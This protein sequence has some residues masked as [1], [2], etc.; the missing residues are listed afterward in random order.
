MADPQLAARGF[1]HALEHPR[2]DAIA[3]PGAPAQLSA[4][5]AGGFAPAPETPE[6]IGLAEL[7]WAPRDA[8]LS[9]AAD[10]LPPLAGVKLLDL[11]QAWIG[12]YAAMLI[13][14]L[15]AEAIK[16]ES[17]RRPDVWRQWGWAPVPL[18]SVD[19]DVVNASPNYNSV[20][21]Q[22]RSL[23]LDLKS[24]AGRG[25]F[26]R[27]AAKADLVME[28]YTPHVLEGF[29]LTWAALAE[30][31]PQ[32]VAASFCGYG[33]TGPLAE[34]K[35]N[36]TTI[37][38]VAG[39]DFFHRYPN[40]DPMVM[41]FYQA[42]AITGLQM[43]ATTLVAYVHRLRTGEGQAID[44]S[45]YEAAVGYIG[46]TLLEAQLG[47]QQTAFG[48]RD[49][50]V[51]PSG[52][53]RCAGPDAWIAITVASDAAWR[54]LAAMAPGVDDAA[55][56]TNTERLQRQDEIERAIEAWTAGEDADAL[57]RRLQG[58][59]VAAARV[60][61]LEDVL[62]C[63]HMSAR[64]WFRRLSH[65]DVGEHAYNGLPW[66]FAGVAAREHR[67]SPRLGEHGREI[68]IRELGLSDAEV[69]AL[70][71]AGVTGAV[72]ASSKEPAGT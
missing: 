16:I 43:A 26:L 33:K 36:G 20:N 17:H 18:T 50:D 41:G 64:A 15:G 58:A 13:A 9:P 70:E 3:A 55:W 56:A 68:L 23:C 14:D 72:L 45:M 42:D 11:T 54:S 24:E 22:K 8:G 60:R 48:N 29:G 10:G 5:P 71:A 38:A 4:T 57:E 40:G 21:L 2:L 1:F 66:R 44:G 39:W 34:F 19:A 51:A 69:D 46:E 65:A 63:P 52:V 59:G 61:N 37:E 27:L 30:R 67:P 49:A 31:N 62:C 35:A 28:N 47:V 25:I 32:I 12:P 7:G 6:A 53:F